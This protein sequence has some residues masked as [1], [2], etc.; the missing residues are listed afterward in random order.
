MVHLS[1]VLCCVVFLRFRSSKP[2]LWNIYYDNLLRLELPPGS[3][4]VGFADDVAV[5]VTA[6]IPALIKS[7]LKSAVNSNPKYR[8]SCLK[9]CVDNK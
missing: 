1:G 4:T 8:C 9:L 7:R 6:H 3:V 5:V 2:A